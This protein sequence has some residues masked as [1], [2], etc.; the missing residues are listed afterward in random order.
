MVDNF[1]SQ[2]SQIVSELE[3]FI[4]FPILSKSLSLD[5]LISSITSSKW[6][7]LKT[8][9]SSFISRI[10]HIFED[11]QQKLCS[12]GG[13]SI[14]EL[15]QKQILKKVAVIICESMI[16]GFSK[17]KR[18]NQQGKEQMKKD[19]K[20]FLAF[21]ELDEKNN[22]KLW[23]EYLEIWSSP[24][25]AIVDWVLN[26]TEMTLRLHR[27]LLSTGLHMTSLNKSARN[28]HVSSVESLYRK[29]IFRT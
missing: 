4:I 1:L 15:I 26:H 23:E 22:R 18:C 29:L 21:A 14:P 3:D 8:E 19:L 17:V 12:L 27:S 7:E 20:A 2:S 24:V 5:W 13:G 11:F 28:G 9:N 25:E 6:E 16:E 10:F